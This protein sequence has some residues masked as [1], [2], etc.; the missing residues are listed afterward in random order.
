MCLLILKNLKRLLRK[1]KSKCSKLEKFG[2]RKITKMFL[3]KYFVTRLRFFKLFF[4]NINYLGMYLYRLLYVP[5]CIVSYNT[6]SVFSAC[7]VR[8]CTSANPSYFSFSLCT[9][10][11]TL[12]ESGLGFRHRLAAAATAATNNKC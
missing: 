1:G 3:K 4:Q 12:A 2:K 11:L 10:N 6:Y 9:D 7:L 5:T 8:K